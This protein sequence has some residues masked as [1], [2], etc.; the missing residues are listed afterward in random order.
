M[1]NLNVKIVLLFNLIIKIIFFLTKKELQTLLLISFV[2][3]YHLYH[4]AFTARSKR[5]TPGGTK[6]VN[7][8]YFRTV[9]KYL[10]I[11]V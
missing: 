3:I 8:K 2:L 11:N 4:F 6:N 7:I 5:S 9:I 1:L 10:K